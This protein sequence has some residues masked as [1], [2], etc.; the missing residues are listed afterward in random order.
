[1]NELTRQAVEEEEAQEAQ[2]RSGILPLPDAP[3]A[4]AAHSAG[5]LPVA[6]TKTKTKALRKAIRRGGTGDA[7]KDSRRRWLQ[8]GR[9][10]LFAYP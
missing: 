1:M 4:T 2:D 9:Q 8:T 6:R 5:W 7:R 10:S 3:H